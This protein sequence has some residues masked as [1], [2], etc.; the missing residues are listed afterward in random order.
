MMN[1]Y[2]QIILGVAGLVVSIGVPVFILV[3][4]SFRSDMHDLRT[5]LKA[6]GDKIDAHIS[7]YEIH[8]VK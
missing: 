2:V 6:L 3:F 1:A 5:D 4:Q 7:N 8:K